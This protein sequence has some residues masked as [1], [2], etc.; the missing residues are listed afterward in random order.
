[1]KKLMLALFLACSVLRADVTVL[2]RGT[3]GHNSRHGVNRLPGLLDQDRPQVLVIGFGANDALNSGAPVELPEFQANI[4]RMIDAAQ[5]AGV[6]TILLNTVNPVIGDYVKARHQY[7]FDEDLNVR[8]ERYNRALRETAAER[9]V[10]LND[11]HKL[12]DEHG[13]ASEKAE[14]PVRNQAN[15]RSRDG[16]HLTAGGARLLGESAAAALKNHIRQGDVI[17]CLGDSITYG[18]AL[19]GAGTSTGSTYPAW[20]EAKLNGRPAP[21]PPVAEKPAAARTLNGNFKADAAGAPP[22]GWVLDKSSGTVGVRQEGERKFISLAPAGD[23][24]A[25]LRTDILPAAPGKYAIALSAGGEG[26][27]EVNGQIYP[28]NSGRPQFF[29]ISGEWISLRT[30]WEEH[31]FEF[32]IP[33]GHDR[34]SLILRQRGGSGNFTDIRMTAAGGK[35]AAA[36]L[37]NRHMKVEFLRPEDGGGVCRIADG[38]GTEFVNRR[39]SGALWEIRMKKINPG[40]SNMPPVITLSIDPEQDDGTSS[41][42]EDAAGNDLAFTSADAVKM[43]AR[44]EIKTSPETVEFSWKGLKIDS[45][46]NALDI[47]AR[48]ELKGDDFFCMADGGFE[49]RSGEYTVFYFALPQLDGLGAVNGAPENDRLATPFFHGRLI[50]NPV[51]K[52]L[53]G[54]NRLFQPNRSG[55]S[56]QF[57]VLCNGGSGLYLGSFDP[58]QYAKRYL[59]E[60]SAA[61]G[62]KWALFNIPDNMRRIPQHWHMPY[63]A[64]FRTFQGDWYDGCMIYREWALRQYWCAEGPL[65]TRRNIPRWFREIDEWFQFG[66]SEINGKIDL[67]E[68]FYSEFKEYKLGAWLTHWGLDNTVFHGMNP[69]RFPLTETDGKTLAY[70]K[71]RNIPVMG[72]IQCTSWNDETGSYRKHAGADANMVRNY[73]GQK[74]KWSGQHKGQE[75]IAYPGELWRQVLGDAVVKMAES[76]FSAVY[77][78]SGNHGGTYLNFTPACSGD[79]GGGTGY[80]K[81]NQMLLAEIRDRARRANPEFCLNAESFWEGN[82]A[83]LDGFLTCN[84]TNAYLEGSRVTPVPMVQAV[85]HDYA[86]MYSAWSGRGDT[87]RDNARGYAAKHALAFCWGVKPGWNIL[88][89]LYRYPNHEEALRTSRLRYEAYSKGKKYL[90]YGRMLREPPAAEPVPTLPVKWHIAY[91][92][93]YYDIM[94][95]KVLKSAWSTPDGGFAAVLY[96]IDEEPQS[97]TLVFDK[98]AYR[99]GAG[100]FTPLYPAGTGCETVDD[101]G[102]Y[103]LKATVPP[104]SPMIL[105]F[106]P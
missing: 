69:E 48:F 76:G 16:L 99:L 103:L 68:K 1:M 105:E 33:A 5:R 24:A 47:R 91:G 70:F 38:K 80:I 17:L 87:E 88:N 77:L 49:N 35:K 67:M 11:F 6:R 65:A 27:F 19:P 78:D 44:C 97:L 36:I 79:S 102:R 100:K 101:G 84:T 104:R 18:A 89:L 57:D 64:G 75:L 12:V 26:S 56:M 37:Q 55:H 66:S 42:N 51:E 60:T 25:F 54:K 95:D 53:L 85:Y 41:K 94:M 28:P 30:Q 39:P 62:L 82:I 61:A 71:Q 40:V 22:A 10:L 63:R 32:E 23:K 31:S 4:G 34:I 46:E 14:S 93:R 92:M 96:N 21:P 8:I 81:Q 50:S 13:G 43:G 98:A 52:N 3:G 20:L 74:L 72:Y 7:P 58:E 45:M 106:T 83:C 2:N 9:N 59:L 90:V 15:S 86:L 73:Y 29:K